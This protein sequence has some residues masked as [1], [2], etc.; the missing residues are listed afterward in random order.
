MESEILHRCLALINDQYSNKYIS[1]YTWLT[2][3]SDAEFLL[4]YQSTY[5]KYNNL[6]CYLS[7]AVNLSNAIWSFYEVER[8]ISKL[9]N[10]VKKFIHCQFKEIKE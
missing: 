7:D 2:Y 6:N 5:K 4:V 9:N 3:T 8:D 10:F 1:F